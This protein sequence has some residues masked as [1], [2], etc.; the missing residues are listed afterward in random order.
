MGGGGWIKLRSQ[1][2]R[3][4][5]QSLLREKRQVQRRSW[6]FGSGRFWTFWRHGAC[7]LVCTCAGRVRAR[8]CGCAHACMRACASVLL[9]RVNVR[10]SARTQAGVRVRVNTY[11][12]TQ[13]RECQHEPAYVRERMYGRVQSS[14]NACV[15]AAKRV[16]TCACYLCVK[17]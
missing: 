8:T 13:V 5:P 3:Y 11:K 17:S 10:E 4:P 2:R 7:A 14:A 9:P 6:P 15:T 12:R 1:P 16:R